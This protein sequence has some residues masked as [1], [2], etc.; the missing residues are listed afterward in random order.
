[1]GKGGKKGSSRAAKAAK[2]GL[3]ALAIA[4]FVVVCCGIGKLHASPFSPLTVE[5][6]SLASSDDAGTVVVDRG[7]TR[8]LFANSADKLTGLYGMEGRETPIDEV[9]VVRQ[10]NGDAL[11]AGVKHAEDGERI[12]TEAVLRFDMSGTYKGVVWRRDYKDDE[13]RVTRSIADL[14][15]DADGNVLM[16]R[17][18]DQQM[19]ALQLDVTVIRIGRDGSEDTVLHEAIHPASSYPY[20]VRIDA[21]SGRLAMTDVFGIMHV[22]RGQGDE[23]EPVRPG[24][25]DLAVQSFDLKGDTAVLYDEKSRSLIRVDDLFGEAQA[26]DIA[27]DARSCDSV[28]MG[29]S[30]VAT[31]DSTGVVTLLEVSGQGAR[32]LQELRLSTSL[33]AGEL[34]L[35][36][37]YAYLSLLSL[38]LVIRWVV[39]AV[40]SGERAKVRNAVAASVTLI[41]GAALTVH[42]IDLTATTLRSRQ[43]AMS[44][45]AS[46]ASVSSPAEFGESATRE[47]RRL[48]GEA[49]AA[50]G[51]DSDVDNVILN[52][53]GILAS[54]FANTNGVQC[55]VYALD[56]E[57]GAAG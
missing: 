49:P 37:S 6:A 38:A 8:L 4:A 42:M 16:A 7:G 10:V 53:E 46:Q 27:R 54:S 11:V 23:A 21:T 13:V 20:D 30:H 12:K 40:R 2:A 47:A 43:S 22:D 52:V 35:Y 51:D 34:I 56:G 15:C 32:T 25:R 26:S 1:M 5:G 3:L 29:G 50:E 24:G 39:R 19:H 44:Q 18:T 57:D 48:T 36:A 45:I 31:V 55:S 14:A 9:S 33:W 41:C 28:A 17:F